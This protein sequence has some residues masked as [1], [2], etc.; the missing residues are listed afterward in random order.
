MSGDGSGVMTWIR[1]GVFRVV[2]V[3]LMGVLTLV[4]CSLDGGTTPAPRLPASVT[5]VVEQPSFPRDLTVLVIGDSVPL[6]LIPALT[7]TARERLGWRVVNASVKVC[8]VYG[9]TLA[10]PDGR[11]H[12]RGGQCRREVQREQRRAVEETDPDVVLWWDRLSTMPILSADGS[13]VRAG[14]ERFW[15][16]R[17]TGLEE[18][19][20]R[21]A[22]RGAF[23]VFVATE[24]IGIG[25]R[26]RC[27]GWKT[28]GC[29]V[30]RRFRLRHYA[31]I[32]RSMN[33]ILRRYAATHPTD[34]AFVTITDTICRRDVSPCDDRMWNGEPARP[35]GT[36][37]GGL[38]EIRAAVAIVRE[39]R[40]AFRT[41]LATTS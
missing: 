40:T 20:D 38:G 12:R 7:R 19:V 13:F 8:T 4:A 32:T 24:P 18:T 41:R 5:P 21:L 30:W 33:G 6:H 22:A 25:I 31:D 16:L 10:W 1:P 11:P 39:L 37:Y 14:S 23:I 15:R 29:V 35:D 9:D 17:M 28:R 26:D 3:A 36:H 2:S 34:A 27:A